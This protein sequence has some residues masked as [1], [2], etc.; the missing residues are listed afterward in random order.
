MVGS[1]TEEAE[2][3]IRLL[4]AS[5][6]QFEP[7]AADYEVDS[8]EQEFNADNGSGNTGKFF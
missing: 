5:M 2:E 8:I 7:G 3:E 4:A 1:G 6:Y